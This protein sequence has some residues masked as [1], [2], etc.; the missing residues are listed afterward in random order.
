MKAK[1][2]VRVL[3]IRPLSTTIEAYAMQLSSRV[4][5]FKYRSIEEVEVV[6]N[7]CCP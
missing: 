4:V 7:E 6:L 3:Q 5:Q 2:R 1:A